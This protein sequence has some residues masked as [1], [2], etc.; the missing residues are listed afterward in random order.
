MSKTTPN[1]KIDKQNT[2]IQKVANSK[3][4]TL[5]PNQFKEFCD[6]LRVLKCDFNDLMIVDGVFRAR[7]IG[8][9][10]IVESAMPFFN[11][12]DISIGKNDSL[13]KDFSILK[14]NEKIQIIVDEENVIFEDSIQRIRVPVTPPHFSDNKFVTIEELRNIFHDNFNYS[15]LMLKASLPKIIVSNLKKIAECYNTKSFMVTHDISDHNRPIL[16]VCTN[17]ENPLNEY[18]LKLDSLFTIPI[19]KNYFTKFSTGVFNFN[20]DDMIMNLFY[21]NKKNIIIAI[22]IT[23]VGDLSVKIYARSAL[24]TSHVDD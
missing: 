24:Y 17:Q 3:S 22:F 16:T 8:S 18:N 2:E 7:S 1:K 5:T 10:F 21:S 23:R 13:L 6:F 4:T 14:K 20:N 19:E 9:T 11:K 12:I 15:Q